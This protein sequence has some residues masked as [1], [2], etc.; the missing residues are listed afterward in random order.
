MT[1]AKTLN[2][3]LSAFLRISSDLK[4]SLQCWNFIPDSLLIHSKCLLLEPVSFYMCCHKLDSL[5]SLFLNFILFFKN[6]VRKGLKSR[7]S[8]FMLI[9]VSMNPTDAKFTIWNV[10]TA[11][12]NLKMAAAQGLFHPKENIWNTKCFNNIACAGYAF[13]LCKNL[14][15]G[16][17]YMWQNEGFQSEIAIL[18]LFWKSHNSNLHFLHFVELL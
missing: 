12:N 1:C 16:M 14:E 17:F 4:I 2:L 15:R 5:H 10:I 11:K 7:N 13:G 3:W 8:I 9:F 6:R 18:T